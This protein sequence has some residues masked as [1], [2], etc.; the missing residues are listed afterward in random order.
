MEKSSRWWEVENFEKI[1][2]CV[3]QLFVNFDNFPK[4]ENSDK[5]WQTCQHPDILHIVRHQLYDDDNND[6]SNDDNNDD[7]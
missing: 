6:D 5:R 1:G 3:C 4:F 7:I 2:N